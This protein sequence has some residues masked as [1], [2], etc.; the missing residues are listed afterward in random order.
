MNFQITLILSPL[1]APQFI[2]NLSHLLSTVRRRRI[3]RSNVTILELFSLIPPESNQR[4]IFTLD[5]LIRWGLL[6]T[7]WSHY[8]ACV[9]IVL[10]AK[11]SLSQ[12]KQLLECHVFIFAA[13][14][15]THSVLEFQ[16]VDD[17]VCFIFSRMWMKIFYER[18]CRTLKSRIFYS[19]RRV[20]YK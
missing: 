13:H 6:T 4:D 11:K 15:R 8:F 2:Q 10:C 18:G 9:K 16:V 17:K 1:L 7:L 14:Y 3:W 12:V 5:S 20:C 19:N